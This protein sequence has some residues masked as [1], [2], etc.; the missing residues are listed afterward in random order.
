M[1]RSSKMPWVQ[2]QVESL[3]KTLKFSISAK[4]QSQGIINQW[5]KVYKSITA[6]YNNILHET[7]I[8]TPMSLIFGPN[9]LDI[10]TNQ[11]SDYVINA[12]IMQLDSWDSEDQNY[13]GISIVESYNYQEIKKFRDKARVQRNI[14][15]DRMVNRSMWPNDRV[16]FYIR[17]RVVRR[18]FLDN[19]RNTRRRV[20]NDNI[21]FGIYVV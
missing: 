15:M 12:V 10:A 3:N 13:T 8:K 21:D 4:C 17:D 16:I 14:S 5:T 19:N 20:L 2:W 7:T 11:Y 18:V 9:Q 6:L 1:K